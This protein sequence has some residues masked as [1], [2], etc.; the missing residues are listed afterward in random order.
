MT[1]VWKCIHYWEITV[2]HTDLFGS[3]YCKFGATFSHSYKF[4]LFLGSAV[5][6]T[7]MM[8]NQFTS[9][10]NLHCII[11]TM[12]NKFSAHLNRTYIYYFQLLEMLDAKT[13]ATYIYIY[14]IFPTLQQYSHSESYISQTR[15]SESWFL[16]SYWPKL[17]QPPS[18]SVALTGHILSTHPYHQITFTYTV[19]KFLPMD[20]QNNLQESQCPL[21][22]G[23]G[24][25]YNTTMHINV[26]YN[27]FFIHS[28]IH[29]FIFSFFWYCPMQC[30]EA[31]RY[32]PFN[33]QNLNATAH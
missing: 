25:I 26:T 4:A 29:S 5:S 12:W 8:L 7:N 15:Y 27:Y 3:I 21:T 20:T 17:A 32:A 22:K 2:L 1:K 16:N 11:F 28:F 23:R 9:S 18:H 33:L 24:G 31:Y 13:G 14:L 6:I 19:H 10:S 30:S